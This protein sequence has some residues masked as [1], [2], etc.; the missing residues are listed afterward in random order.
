MA[1]KLMP[2]WDHIEELRRTFL[3]SI[4]VIG[5]GM[6][7]ALIFYQEVLDLLT[8]PLK[9]AHPLSG[10]ELTR[11]DLH[12]ERII[13]SGS[14]LVTYKL[15]P[16]ATL[17]GHSADVQQIDAQTLLLPPGASLDLDITGKRRELA[18]FGPIEGLM[19]ALK[20]AFWIGLVATCPLWCLFSM[21]FI[22]PALKAD[23]QR[24]LIPFGISSL[25]G[26]CAGFAFAFWL[27]IPIANRVLF[28]FNAEIGTNLWA[29][30]SYLDYTVLLLLAHGLA[31]ELAVVLVFLV[32]L[33]FVT[34]R[35]MR[36]RR[37]YVIV[38]TLVLAAILTPPDV[39]TQVLLAIPLLLLY[40][41][42]ILYALIREKRR[43]KNYVLLEERI[44]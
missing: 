2:F 20:V 15:S 41:M 34:A 32:H 3:R 29:L 5:A 31:F 17:S 13:N 21:R 11:Q 24:L 27:T 26:I 10:Y 23:E 33:G 36:T 8:L 38:G 9:A 18:I 19:T 14:N 44:I 6:L 28:S 42:I 43:K 40:E 22:A 7:L 39:F 16:D 4:A 37:R 25:V 1:E 30:T 12:R 35:G